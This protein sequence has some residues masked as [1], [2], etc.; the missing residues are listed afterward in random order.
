[1]ATPS[2]NRLVIFLHS[3]EYAAVHEGLSA[4]AA[5]AALGR[6]T[7]IYLF[8]W[9]LD[10][11]L[12]DK[13]DE[14]DFGPGREELALDFVDRHFPTLRELLDACRSTGLVSLWACSGSLAVLGKTPQALEGKVDGLVGWTSIL[15]RTSGV[16][17]RISL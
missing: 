14:P 13:L 9:A 2:E 11:I 6:R 12:G 8:W 10:R 5:A 4:A 17:D 16:V 1:M 7:D 15:E 3:G